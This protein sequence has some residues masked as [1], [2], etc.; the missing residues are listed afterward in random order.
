MFYNDKTKSC[1]EDIKEKACYI[2]LDFQEELK[3]IESYYYALPDDKNL[4]INEER[5]KAP[6][7]LFKPSLLGK[8]D[9]IEVFILKSKKSHNLR[10]SSHHLWS[11]I[12]FLGVGHYFLHFNNIFKI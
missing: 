5:I 12:I 3:G 1:V 2:A 6:E 8:D 11:R 7:A 9:S 10:N 4:I